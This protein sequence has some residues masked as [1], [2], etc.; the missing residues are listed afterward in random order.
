M[1][2]FL[3]LAVILGLGC[4]Q[5]SAPAPAPV[6]LPAGLTAADTA[7]GNELYHGLGRCNACHGD[8]GVGTPDGPSLIA[9]RWKLVDGSYESLVH[10]TRHAGPGLVDRGDGDPSSMRGPGVLDSVQVRQV[11][12]YVWTISRAVRPPRQ[13]PGS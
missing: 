8:E 13:P 7:T 1:R 5:Q 2:Q 11:A 6:S 4:G 10:I 3:A 12:G 9:G